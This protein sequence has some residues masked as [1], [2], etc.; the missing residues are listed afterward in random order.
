MACQSAEG[1]PVRPRRCLVSSSAPTAG[2]VEQ[3]GGIELAR[4]WW[5]GSDVRHR[6][7]CRQASGFERRAS[8]VERT[9]SLTTASSDH[10]GGPQG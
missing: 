2:K 4:G 1:I 5:M 3:D 9:M 6:R 10:G 7:E 8:I